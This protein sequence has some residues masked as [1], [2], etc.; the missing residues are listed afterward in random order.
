[1]F[2]GTAREDFSRGVFLEYVCSLESE[3]LK[4]VRSILERGVDPRRRDALGSAA[5]QGHVEIVLLLLG[6]TRYRKETVRRALEEARRAAIASE[7]LKGR[8]EV[9]TLLER[10]V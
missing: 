3:E 9:V 1:M 7:N 8:A 6:H 10:H 2:L 4:L 5:R